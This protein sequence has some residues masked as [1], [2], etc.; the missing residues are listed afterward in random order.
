MKRFSLR[1]QSSIFT[2]TAIAILGTSGIAKADTDLN[3]KYFKVTTLVPVFLDGTTPTVAGKPTEFSSGVTECMIRSSSA[4]DQQIS[5]VFVFSGAQGSSFMTGLY[6]EDYM[7]NPESPEALEREEKA[8]KQAKREGLDE[9]SINSMHSVGNL[10][11]STTD[12]SNLSSEGIT[13]ALS[14]Q[15]NVQYG[16]EIVEED[17]GE[18]EELKSETQPDEQAF[19]QSKSTDENIEKREENSVVTNETAVELISS[20]FTS[21][22]LSSRLSAAE[23]FLL[24]QGYSGQEAKDLSVSL[25][26]TVTFD[27]NDAVYSRYADKSSAQ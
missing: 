6:P 21:E 24:G 11:C 18:S 27:P 25:A 1:S 12:G 23:V 8:K 19:T 4:V 2:I 9:P 3:D 17:S 7:L 15:F 10:I 5:G 20:Y 13:A 14:N 26:R 22:Q 16:D